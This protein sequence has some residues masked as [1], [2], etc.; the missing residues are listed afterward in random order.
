M[1]HRRFALLFALSTL[2]ASPVWAASVTYLQFGSFE[3]RAEAE[4]RLN[5]VKQK[6]AAVIGTMDVTIR[7]VKLPPDNL[8]VYR[9]QAGPVASK[10][11]A[12]SICSQLAAQGDEC[13][14][15]QTAMIDTPPSVASAANAVAAA[16]AVP[17]QAVAK[18]NDVATGARDT[19]AN[20]PNASASLNADLAQ[21]FSAQASARDPRSVA[22]LASVSPTS[23]TLAPAAPAVNDAA[24]AG[25]PSLAPLTESSSNAAAT[26]PPAPANS[27]ELQAALDRAVANEAQ[28]NASVVPPQTAAP[29]S[30]WSRLNPFNSAT[31]TPAAPAAP[32]ANVAALAPPVIP[33]STTP[34]AAPAET[35]AFAVPL[36]P[37]Q[38]AGGAVPAGAPVAASV[39]LP[40]LS[41]QTPAGVPSPVLAAA[42]E[43]QPQPQPQPVV[44]AQA[45]LSTPSLQLPP[46][47]APLK[48]FNA[49]PTAPLM[50]EP[51]GSIVARPI[52]AGPQSFGAAPGSV[53]VEE[54]Q[55]V[56]L[57][58]NALPPVSTL[59]AQTVPVLPLS[60]SATLG[61]KTF[62]AQ[63]GPFAD[64]QEALAFWDQYRLMHPDFPVVRVRVT[65][66]LLAQERGSTSQ[67]LRVGPFAREGFI[68]SLCSSL[69]DAEGEKLREDLKCG[70][71]T[72]L[73]VASSGTRV[74][75]YL[76][77]SRY[78]R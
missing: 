48:G 63:M 19:L 68:S 45:P 25:Q 61:Q 20:T 78:S 7:E 69:V 43:P 72:D 50:P 70:R 58:Q 57:T 1:T 21:P 42:P 17:G 46:P 28:V 40:P 37:L 77:G 54:A 36:A 34:V 15:V 13:Y 3:T 76:P 38:P 5:L 66:S 33:V 49:A 51:T 12:Q 22:A 2:L 59:P 26:L 62:W 47:P 39:A 73:G 10:A 53:K 11:T 67:W 41:A 29:R 31:P 9:T 6:N 32:P 27:P 75:G 18:A 24:S 60:P 65:A 52:P 74:P 44:L 35:P 8:T 23:A 16:S 55:R 64:T 30:F 56:P 71:V 4:T 14:V